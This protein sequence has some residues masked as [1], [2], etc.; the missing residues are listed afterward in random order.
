MFRL[1][2]IVITAF[3]YMIPFGLPVL[4]L[5][6]LTG[7]FFPRLRDW[8][9]WF[10]VKGITKIILHISGCRLHVLGE[11]NI[12]QDRTVL[13]VSNHRSF[14]DIFVY[15]QLL[16]RPTGS[17]TKKEWASYPLIR[18]WMK[19]VHCVFVDRSSAR[20]GLESMND[21]I[22][23]MNKGFSF[24]ICPEGTRSHSD[25]LLPFHH[26]S[27][28]AAFKTAYPIVPVTITGTDDLFENHLPKVRPAEVTI[29]FD[30]PIETEGLDRSEQAE[31][32][33]RIHTRIQE[34]Y[35][36]LH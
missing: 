29:S 3:I 22:A 18:V 5:L 33:D 6:W 11:E 26:G 9:S 21:L 8:G 23:Q 35:N 4:L 36:K 20:A 32:I 2:L 34:Q 27:F 24:W 25:E 30:E 13:Y 14:F 16:R 17:L 19:Y 1:V 28:K 12:P 7:I 10:F 31:L 15:L